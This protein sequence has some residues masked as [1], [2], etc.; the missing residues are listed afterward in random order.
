M[1]LKSALAL[2]AATAALTGFAGAFWLAYGSEIYLD[3]L[4]TAFINCF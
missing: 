4:A 3:R 2:V 1:S